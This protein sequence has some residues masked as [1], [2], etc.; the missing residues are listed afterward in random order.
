MPAT[1]GGLRGGWNSA[2]F[3]Y[4]NS[5]QST[6]VI[7]PSFKDRLERG[8]KAYAVSTVAQVNLDYD[9][10]LQLENGLF[11]QWTRSIMSMG[12]YWHSVHPLTR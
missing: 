5:V 8:E 11:T 6:T 2:E 10:I 3:F 4:Q 1:A 9:K 12:V 7:G